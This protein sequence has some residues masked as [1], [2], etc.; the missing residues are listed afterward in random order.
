M[1]EELLMHH[2]VS[3]SWVLKNPSAENDDASCRLGMY[4]TISCKMFVT[5]FSN[6]PSTG[7]TSSWSTKV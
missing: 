6:H 7:A 3:N 5:S 2:V 4:K 1:T